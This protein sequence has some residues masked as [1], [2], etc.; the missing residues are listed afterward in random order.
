[1][2]RVRSRFLRAVVATLLNQATTR[3]GGSSLICSTATAC[4]R[5]AESS[6]PYSSDTK[7][8][9]VYDVSKVFAIVSQAASNPSVLP[10]GDEA[11]SS[12]ATV[13]RRCRSS[14]SRTS[15]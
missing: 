11:T 10:K 12:R 3:S 1:M 5:A 15:V 8:S 2:S 6:R 4:V 14:P 13:R 9:S 7:P